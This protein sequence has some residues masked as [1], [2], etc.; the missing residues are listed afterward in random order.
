MPFKFENLNVWHRSLDL[1]EEVNELVKSFPSF[2]FQN[3]SLQMRRA[4]DSVSLNIAEGC[5]GQ[6]NREFARFL[7]YSIRSALE[8][9]GCLF[10]ANRKKY[11]Q[12][13]R[14]DHFYLQ[15]ESLVKMLTALRQSLN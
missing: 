8:V 5:T 4:A 13:E 11:I 12:K 3:L 2:E 10:L 14:F 15:Y 7:N 6:S 1:S 9:V